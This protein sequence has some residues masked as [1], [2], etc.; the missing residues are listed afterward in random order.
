V[1]LLTTHSMEEADVLGDRIA[2]FAG[3]KL[4]CLGTALHLKAKHGQG[5][6][7]GI[8]L[9]QQGGGSS[10]G[11]GGS[12]VGG[13]DSGSAAAGASRQAVEALVQQVLGCQVAAHEAGES[14]LQFQLPSACRQKLPQ[15]LQQL[16]DRAQELGVA[17]VQV[18]CPSAAC[19]RRST[20]PSASVALPRKADAAIQ[21]DRLQG[22]KLLLPAQVGMAPLEEVFLR[23]AEQAQA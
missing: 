5:Y 4:R 20:K 10:S 18:R 11:G 9:Q 6:R 19:W 2:V 1:L 23:V 21:P 13:D 14:G 17:G 22:G 7:L 3:G 15:L 8:G 12:G 16:Q